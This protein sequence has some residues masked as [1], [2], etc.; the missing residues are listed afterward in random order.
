MKI[1]AA[2]AVVAACLTV[3]CATRPAPEPTAQV[4]R[5]RAPIN[6]EQ[7]IT[8]FYD[9]TIAGPQ[10][11]REL[12]FGAPERGTCSMSS[13]NQSGH[14]GW[15]VPVQYKTKGADSRVTITSQFF[16]FSE[17]TIK[18]VTRRMELCP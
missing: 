4:V 13:R 2:L 7:T 11:G 18:G 17:E 1:A 6:Y 3:G 10:K 16:W 15:V 9:L 12:E 5:T 8:N 14:L